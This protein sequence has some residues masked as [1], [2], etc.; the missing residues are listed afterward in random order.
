MHHSRVMRRIQ[1]RCNLQEYGYGFLRSQL[2]FVMQK[3]A[4]ISPLDVLHGD[5]S[6]PA[7]LPQ[8]ENADDVA[9]GNFARENEFLFEAPQDFRMAGEVGTNHL[10]CNRALQFDVAR[11]VDG[12]H[13]ALTEQLQD[14]VAIAEHAP[15]LKLSFCRGLT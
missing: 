12:P 15:R 3:G 8:I 7:R 2:P 11:L 10:H 14:F 6:D 13:P 4:Q 9:V 1:R 5:V